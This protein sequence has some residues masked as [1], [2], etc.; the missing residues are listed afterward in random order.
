MSFENK[1]LRII[2]YLENEFGWSV[3]SGTDTYCPACH[4]A[5]PTE[6]KFCQYCG[7]A[8]VLADGTAVKQL[9]EALQWVFGDKH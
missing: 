4:H 3:M 1:A 7:T 6:T 5:F 9:E 8:L 2:S